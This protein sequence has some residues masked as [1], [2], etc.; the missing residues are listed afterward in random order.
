MDAGFSSHLLTVL[1]YRLDA[2]GI[3]CFAILWGV[4]ANSKASGLAARPPTVEAVAAALVTA[5]VVGAAMM[6]WPHNAVEAAAHSSETPFS[7]GVRVVVASSACAALYLRSKPAAGL[8]LVYVAG[9]IFLPLV[10]VGAITYVQ[11]LIG[12]I[13]GMAAIL[14]VTFG[15]GRFAATGLL[16]SFRE[17]HRPLFHALAFVVSL[18]FATAFGSV[19]AIGLWL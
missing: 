1:S 3:L 10:H 18:E 12:T 19:R 9:C 16:E 11:G 13:F 15:V 8:F 7:G 2:Q 4:L 5:L 14:A 6:G 17:N